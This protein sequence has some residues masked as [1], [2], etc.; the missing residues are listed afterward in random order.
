M[1]NRRLHTDSKERAETIVRIVL[2]LVILPY[3]AISGDGWLS[4]RK[5]RQL[6]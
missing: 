5:R 2:G 3:G 4:R 6:T 1:F